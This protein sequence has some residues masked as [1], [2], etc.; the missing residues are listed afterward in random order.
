VANKPHTW[1]IRPDA[2]IVVQTWRDNAWGAMIEQPD[3]ADGFEGV[4]LPREVTL[5]PAANEAPA[6]R[7]HDDAAEKCIIARSATGRVEDEPSFAAGG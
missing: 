3:G 4:T 2:R 6:H 5:A 7:L 1:A